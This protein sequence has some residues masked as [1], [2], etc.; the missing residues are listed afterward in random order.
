MFRFYLRCAAAMLISFSI[1]CYPMMHQQYPAPGTYGVPGGYMGQPGAV[2]QPLD[3]QPA[4]DDAV[5]TFDENTTPDDDF[6]RG[7]F[8][9]S[10][11]GVPNPQDPMDGMFQPE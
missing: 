4:Q 8:Y 2:V 3:S 11:G 9:D 5:K 7:Q 1:G 6:N 10:Q